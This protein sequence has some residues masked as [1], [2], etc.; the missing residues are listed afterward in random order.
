MFETMEVMYQY[1]WEFI[2]NVLKLFGIEKD[3]NGDLI[4]KAE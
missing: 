4:E 1:L 2:Y 3:E